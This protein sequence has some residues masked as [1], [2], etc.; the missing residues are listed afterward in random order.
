VYPSSSTPIISHPHRVW[1]CNSLFGRRWRRKPT[2]G[3]RRRC[4]RCGATW[5]RSRAAL[6]AAHA[7]GARVLPRVCDCTH[8]RARTPAPRESLQSAPRGALPLSLSGFLASLRVRGRL[9][10]ATRQSSAEPSAAGFELTERGVLEGGE[11]VVLSAEEA[12]GRLQ[13][14]PG[15]ARP[16][17]EPQ[18]T[19]R[20]IQPTKHS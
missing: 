3:R 4:S 8:P 17:R 6:A 14:E 15:R 20:E 16:R 10:S 1:G 18:V 12:G 5:R 9:S 2:G 7:G 11:E 19:Q 13:G